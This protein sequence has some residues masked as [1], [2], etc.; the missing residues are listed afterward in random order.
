MYVMIL[1]TLFIAPLLAFFLSWMYMKKKNVHGIPIVKG[2]IPILGNVLSLPNESERMKIFKS[3][4]EEYGTTHAF[5]ILHYL[6]VFCS[7]PLVIAD[8]LSSQ[9]LLT[10]S[11]SYW[12]LKEMLGGG[13]VVSDGELW[14]RRRRIIT[15]T[16][17]FNILGEYFPIIQ[18]HTEELVSKLHG[19]T[20]DEFDIFPV[21]KEHSLSIICDTAMGV[22]IRNDSEMKKYSH[23]LENIFNL[24]ATR[25]QQPWFWIAWVFKLTQNGKDY[26]KALDNLRNFVKDIIERR[27]EMRNSS[28][29]DESVQ[30]SSCKNRI[31]LDTML[32]AYQTGDIDVD[33]MIDEVNT[34]VVAGLETVSTAISWC[35]YSLAA[36]RDVQERA[37]EE[38]L[39]IENLADTNRFIVLKEMK[40]IDCVVKESLR[41]RP[42][43]PYVARSIEKDTEIG[44]KI[45]P[46]CDL[47]VSLLFLHRNPEIWENPMS[48]IPERFENLSEKQKSAFSSIP[49]SAGP[50]NCIGQRFAMMEIKVAIYH[51][52]KN[53]DVTTTQKESEIVEK[54]TGSYGSENGLLLRLKNIQPK[55]E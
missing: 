49:F 47:A 43:I 11:G 18:K 1:M 14:K 38:V 3:W 6:M 46:P 55:T 16:F 53:F 2:A 41:L 52:L 31:F 25:D 23:W 24:I 39:R 9:K 51:I 45:F 17:H 40:Y 26:Y 21:A 15:P 22:D 44:G 50:R 7:D 42:P 54:I 34:F 4:E 28:L 20:K 48:F 30:I 36:N 29:S 5:W 8:L 19:Y 13:L 10:K 35:L 27:I 33:G 37:R 12:T 32:D